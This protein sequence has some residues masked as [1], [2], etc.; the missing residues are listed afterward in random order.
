MM[1]FFSFRISA[2]FLAQESAKRDQQ[3]KRV[4]PKKMDQVERLGMALGDSG[5][6]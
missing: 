3:M 2:R 5:R 4:D 1:S 6:G